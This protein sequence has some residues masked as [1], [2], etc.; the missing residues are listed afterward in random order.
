MYAKMTGHDILSIFTNSTF[1]SSA[2][3]SS[4]SSRTISTST[5]LKLSSAPEACRYKSGDDSSAERL[6]LPI[7]PTV[8]PR[9]QRSRCCRR[10]VRTTEGPPKPLSTYDRRGSGPA[11]D[12]TL[13]VIGISSTCRIQADNSNLESLRGV[14]RGRPFPPDKQAHFLYVKTIAYLYQWEA[15]DV[16]SRRGPFERL[17]DF[18]GVGPLGLP[19]LKAKIPLSSWTSVGRAFGMPHILGKYLADH[20]PVLHAL[21][22]FRGIGPQIARAVCA[23]LHFHDALT[24]GDMSERQLNQLAHELGNYKLENDSLREVQENIARLRR[25]GCYRGRRHAA[26]LPV[27]G[28][29]SQTNARTAR[30]LNKVERK[31]HTTTTP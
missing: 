14:G 4:I 26:G 31:Y 9:N 7:F 15:P 21:K 27:R 19:A 8:R 22:L 11:A 1:K 29:N 28:Q 25:I 12:D 18:L 10:L 6:C 20:R 30:K 17:S 24:M 13:H 23:K 16:Q 5:S 2:L 3:R